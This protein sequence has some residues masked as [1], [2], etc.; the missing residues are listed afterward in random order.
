MNPAFILLDGFDTIK[1]QLS[2]NNTHINKIVQVSC[3]VGLAVGLVFCIYKI[4]K[5]DS[6]GWS[7]LLYW[8][9]ALAFWGAINLTVGL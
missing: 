8:F 1:T 7:Y 3:N 5:G 4:A 2:A 9:I 6:R